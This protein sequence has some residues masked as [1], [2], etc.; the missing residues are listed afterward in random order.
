MIEG[1]GGVLLVQNRRR[2]GHHD[3]SPPGGVIEVADGETLIDGLTREVREE[4]GLLVTEWSGPIYEIDAE[5]P[6]L[7]WTLR[8]EVFAAVAFDGDLVIDD[9][10]GVVVDARYVAVDA[11]G[12]HLEGNHPWVTEPLLEWLHGPRSGLRSYSYRV[13]G[14]DIRRLQVTRL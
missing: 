5:A 6:G 1:P 14:D 13:D 4:T 2:G 9:P 11:C 8:V 3:W 12:D 7:G 10:D